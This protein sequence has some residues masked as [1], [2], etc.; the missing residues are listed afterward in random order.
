MDHEV[1]HA[2]FASI[3]LLTAFTEAVQKN[4]KAQRHF[5]T[6]SCTAV[7]FCTATNSL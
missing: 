6:S 2:I 4:S 3:L 1:Q 5:V 7:T